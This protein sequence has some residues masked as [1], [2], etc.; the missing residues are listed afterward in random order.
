MIFS[1][2]RLTNFVH[3]DESECYRPSDKVVN[4]CTTWIGGGVLSVLVSWRIRC[5][6]VRYSIARV[7]EIGISEFQRI[8]VFLHSSL[9]VLIKS[10]FR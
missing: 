3:G 8:A 7:F 1:F 2:T 6:S 9:K 10:L 5:I 4:P